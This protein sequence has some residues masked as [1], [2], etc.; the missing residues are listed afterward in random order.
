MMLTQTMRKKADREEG[1]ELEF[2][3]MLDLGLDGLPRSI[4]ESSI[5]TGKDLQQFAK[6]KVIPSQ[7]SIER[8]AERFRLTKDQRP[9][10]YHKRAKQLL[11]KDSV[12]DAIKV[13]LYK[14]R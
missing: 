1:T 11:R 2:F 3:S 8:C 5:F 9:E 14:G 10:Y 6:L 12:K 4:L 7:A 13:A